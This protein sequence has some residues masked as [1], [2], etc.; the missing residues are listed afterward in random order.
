LK[1]KALTA[2]FSVVRN[3]QELLLDPNWTQIYIAAAAGQHS[4][5]WLVCPSTSVITRP[6]G[7]RGLGLWHF[8]VEFRMFKVDNYKT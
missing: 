3:T 1:L 6:A 7:L 8:V 5:Y 2:H 4:P